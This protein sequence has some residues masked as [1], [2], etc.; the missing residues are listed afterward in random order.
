V[1]AK[2]PNGITA[3]QIMAALKSDYGLTPRPNH[4]GIALQRHSRAGRLQERGGAWYTPGAIAK[5]A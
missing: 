2:Y 3:P 4:L 1:V 5:A